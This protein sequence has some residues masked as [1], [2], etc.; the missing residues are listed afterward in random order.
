MLE[1]LRGFQEVPLSLLGASGGR[2]RAPGTPN[3]KIKPQCVFGAND[4][5][6]Q[7]AA[8][9]GRPTNATKTIR[10]GHRNVIQPL[11]KLTLL[12]I[13]PENF[14]LGNDPPKLDAR[15]SRKPNL[16]TRAPNKAQNNCF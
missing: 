15:G 3:S 10:K 9:L 8:W 7:D 14:F 4:H 2:P 16:A 11:R 1:P 13:C 5:A 12:E 6:K